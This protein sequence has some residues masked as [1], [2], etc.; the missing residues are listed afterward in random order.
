MVRIRT[1]FR[2]FLMAGV[3]LFTIAAVL[4]LTPAPLEQPASPQVLTQEEL[5]PSGKDGQILAPGIPRSVPEYTINQFDY[6]STRNGE[7]QW[8]LFA[9]RA[10]LFNQEK[11]VHSRSV[12]AH[13]YG[14]D[15][16]ITEVVGQEAKYGMDDQNLE[17]FG[18][19]KATL[20]D[21]FEIESEYLKYDASRRRIEIPKAYDVAGRGRSGM[22]PALSFQSKGFELDMRREKTVLP[23]SARVTLTR[24][25]AQERRFSE[26]TTVVSDQATIFQDERLVRFTMYPSR[27][28]ESRFIQITQ[29]QL[30]ARSRKAELRYGDEINAAPRG[31]EYL[32]LN[33][34]VLI[35]EQ[36]DGKVP[37]YATSGEARFDS[38]KDWIILREF[39][40][41]YQDNDTVTGDIIIVHRDTD[42]VEVEH[43]NAYSAGGNTGNQRNR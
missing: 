22:D 32:V 4:M 8:Q 2:L 14:A 13:L 16:K 26:K 21:G 7:K 11:L 35:R 39:P 27:P 38:L 29:P 40:Q 24:T 33:E 12:K 23:K 30:A 42:I 37:R 1:V 28:L 19:V 10:F 6:V 43:S 25:P 18:S 31:V 20:P 41:V 34:E 17:M 36:G 9:R 15:G 5:I 3:A